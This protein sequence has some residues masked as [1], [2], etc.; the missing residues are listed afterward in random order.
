MYFNTI[1]KAVV[2]TSLL[3]MLYAQ[4]DLTIAVGANGTE[5]VMATVSR[6]Q[7]SGIFPDDNRFLRRVAFAESRD[8]LDS[9]TFRDGYFGG[10]WQVDEAIF[11]VTLNVT[12]HPELARSGGI[13]DGISNSFNVEWRAVTWQDLRRP[14][15]SA[16]A[17]RIFF[18]LAEGNIPDIGDVRGQGRYW[19][20]TG[21]NTNPG[22]TVDFFVQTINTLEL[23]GEIIV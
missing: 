14:L 16:L 2:L 1:I 22:D 7:Q 8:G 11:L 3:G 6:I 9:D 19:K 20:D 12:A 5:V 4:R 18:E 17:A 10:I 13:F 15:F 21:F 23:E